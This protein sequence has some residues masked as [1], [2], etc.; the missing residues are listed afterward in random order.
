[1]LKRTLEGLLLIRTFRLLRKVIPPPLR[2]KGIV[3]LGSVFLNSVTDLIGLATLIPLFMVII[4]ESKIHSNAF[5]NFLYNSFHF[6]SNKMFVVF[7]CCAV[8]TFI[9]IKNLVS[10]FLISVQ[11]KFSFSLYKYFSSRLYAYY[12]SQGLLYLKE[13][14]SNKIVNNI[15]YNVLSFVQN[16]VMGCLGLINEF[17]IIGLI[18]V[19]ILVYNPTAILILLLTVF[20][21]VIIFSRIVKSKLTTLGKEMSGLHVNLNKGI[22]ESL[23]GYSDFV[24]RNKS[25]W[26]YQRL[27]RLLTK[28]SSRQIKKYVLLQIPAKVIETAIVLSLIAIVLFSIFVNVDLA[29]LSVLLGVFGLAAYR[30]LPSLNKLMLYIMN[31]RNNQF[32]FEI[33]EKTDYKQVIKAA[34]SVQ[35]KET[36]SFKEKL[37][38]RN[39]SFSFDRINKKVIKD[40][41]IEIPKGE[42]LGI[43]GRSGSGKT[44]LLNILLRFYNQQSGEILVDNVV[45]NEEQT[46][47]WRN[48]IGYVPQEVFI[49]DASLAENIALGEDLENIDF[50]WLDVV[51]KLA[52][53]QPVVNALDEGVR[54]NIGE[55]GGK[56]SG[57]QKQR[58][59]IARALYNRAQIL[60]FDEATS[61][62]DSETE[63]EI[64]NS[65]LHL[66]SINKDLTIIIIAHRISSLKHCSR[67]IELENGSVKKEWNY[68]D[69]IQ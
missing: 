63:E 41:S 29:N 16:V 27:S 14:N 49:M 13:H 52:R 53:L 12:Y 58:L 54:T 15:S 59:G 45:L 55:R 65:I 18:I 22:L 61:S 50:E 20:P 32:V 25:Y 3:A 30:I 51:I 17:L 69:L 4:D 47:R 43:I 19:G 34:H 21:I 28:M 1:M 66:S 40:F 68:A 35:P 9:I 23:H 33:I 48:I 26:T 8:L 42:R 2:R 39:I 11:T 56:L 46:S 38:L 31:I 36:I 7:L 62:L 10:I 5:L 44:T 60:F 67:I 37:E 24:I 57:G 6:S 64:N